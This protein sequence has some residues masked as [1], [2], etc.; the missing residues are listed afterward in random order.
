M[1]GERLCVHFLFDFVKPAFAYVDYDISYV[2]VS[3]IRSTLLLC[4]VRKERGIMRY[5]K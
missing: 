1:N 2:S 5:I 3:R 4:L